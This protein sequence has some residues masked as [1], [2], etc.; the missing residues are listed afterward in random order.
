MRAPAGSTT[1]PEATGGVLAMVTTG[2]VTGAPNSM[3]SEG[4]TTKA[5][6]CPR[7]VSDEATVLPVRAGWV[8]P[9]FVHES[10]VGPSGSPSASLKV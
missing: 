6:C 9:S 7:A 8:T 4:R 1:P 5:H 2:E 3:P 10:V